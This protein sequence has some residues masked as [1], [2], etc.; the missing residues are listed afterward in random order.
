MRITGKNN[1]EVLTTPLFLPIGI[2]VGYH[3]VESKEDQISVPQFQ[4]GSG[5]KATSA[6]SPDEKNTGFGVVIPIE[7]VFDIVE[8]DLVKKGIEASAESYFKSSGYVPSAA[9]VS[10]AK[11]APS[12]TDENPQHKEDFTRLVGVAAK[13]PKPAE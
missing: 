11:S 13:T 7:R 10:P 1:I 3:V 2:L 8:S 9:P 5:A 12:T 4:T 6:A